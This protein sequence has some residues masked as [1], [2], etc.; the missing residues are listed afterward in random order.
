[1]E[2]TPQLLTDEI[3]FRVALRGY[4]RN[5]VDDFLERVAVAV[6]QLQQ[7]LAKAVE[8]ARKAEKQAAARPSE[9]TPKKPSQEEKVERAEASETVTPTPAPE[10]VVA[11]VVAKE[12]AEPAKPAPQVEVDL[13][14]EL[15]RTLVLA[16]R[17]ADTAIREAREEAEGI[18]SGAKA[19]AQ[20]T[21]DEAEAT[22]R[23]KREEARARLVDEITELEAVRESLR[24]DASVLER[25]LGDERARVRE[26]IQVLRRLVDDPK[27]FQVKPEPALS[28][29][30]VPDEVRGALATGDT[31]TRE[32]GSG[33]TADDAEAPSSTEA[34]ESAP[35]ESEHPEDHLAKTEASDEPASTDTAITPSQTLPPPAPRAEH[36]EPS[37]AAP[38]KVSAEG[39]PSEASPGE[40]PKA[41]AVP[42]VPNAQAAPE[43]PK[44]Q[45]APESPKAQAAPQTSN[46]GHSS[47]RDAKSPD[48]VFAGIPDSDLAR[49]FDTGQHTSF[50]WR[51]GKDGRGDQGP[52]TQP[53]AAARFEEE[54][55]DAFL[56]EL[57]RAMTDN[58]PLGPDDGNRK[59]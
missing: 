57:R 8:R 54:P 20:A 46:R 1:M 10:P 55:D 58:E 59:I 48:G 49:L 9:S 37:A 31:S 34:T 25:Y 28:G 2:L 11:P 12:P 36:A 43:S 52:H 51:E 16:Q 19:E 41:Q 13:N 7:Q 50:D 27:S 24:D 47:S 32:L 45:P 38:D 4:D 15:R 26:T 40:A 14:D 42:E 29:I 30:T 18:V 21:L 22:G 23:R 53:M 6:G 35:S 39:Q 5:E 33:D 17:T 3:D 44:A 56:A